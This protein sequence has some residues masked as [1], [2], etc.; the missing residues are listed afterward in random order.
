MRPS[1]RV[2]FVLRSLTLGAL[3]TLGSLGCVGGVEQTD[4]PSGDDG[5]PVV[6]P[7]P[8]GGNNAEALVQ[9]WSGCMSIDNFRL[10][11]MNTAWGTLAAGNG[12]ACSSC[13]ST[14]FEGFY[15]DRD[16][17]GMFQAITTTKQFL[18]Q[19]FSPDVP[20]NKMIVNLSVFTAVGTNQPPH[21]AHPPFN[22][23]TNAGM[24]ALKAFYDTTMT[25]QQAH[26]C[27]QPRLTP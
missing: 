23:T 10:A 25:R 18:L 6:T 9:E 8:P 17:A 19:Y 14:G 12:Q 20:N 7:T 24:T 15:A 26:T 11:K 13:H 16:E 2:I 27:D 5:P 3:A 21:Q 4:P 22:P 1:Q